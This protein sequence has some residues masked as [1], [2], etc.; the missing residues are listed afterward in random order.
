MKTK[1][2][3]EQ[4]SPLSSGGLAPPRGPFV[5]YKIIIL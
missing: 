5:P 2:L 4:E 1:I 3:S